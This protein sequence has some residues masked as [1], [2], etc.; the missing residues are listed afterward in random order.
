LAQPAFYANI[1]LA[2]GPAPARAYIEALLPDV[3]AGRIQPGCVF[4]CVVRLEQ[5]PDG[6]RVMDE[7]LAIKVLINL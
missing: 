2:G 6:Y 4:D 3:L 7:R 1:T 5:V